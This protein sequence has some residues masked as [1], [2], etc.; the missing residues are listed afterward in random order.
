MVPTRCS[1]MRLCESLFRE[2]VHCLG[3]VPTQECRA[4]GRWASRQKPQYAA[5]PKLYR[6]WSTM[7]T[8][9]V[10]VP[11][12][13]VKQAAAL[14]LFPVLQVATPHHSPSSTQTL[15]FAGRTPG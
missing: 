7:Q 11:P 8:F 10:Q 3:I 5:M 14:P 6:K 1:S 9:I 12:V 4:I 2:F 15:A 13:I